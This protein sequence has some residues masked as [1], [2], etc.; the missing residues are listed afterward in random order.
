M[1]ARAMVDGLAGIGLESSQRGDIFSFVGCLYF[2]H[3]LMLIY[4]VA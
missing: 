3:E 2:A 1:E 4:P